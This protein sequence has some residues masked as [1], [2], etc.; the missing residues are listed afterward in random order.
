MPLKRIPW[1]LLLGEEVEARE[2]GV[3]LEGGL[4][5]YTI[6]DTEDTATVVD[7]TA[8]K[9]GDALLLEQARKGRDEEDATL[10]ARKLKKTRLTNPLTT[11][12]EETQLPE[13]RNLQTLEK[14]QQPVL[15]PPTKRRKIRMTS[16]N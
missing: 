4:L 6:T 11:T 15:V 2:V 9:T 14:A 10:M 3:A 8:R 12:S 1:Q 16:T 7:T 5:K 13:G